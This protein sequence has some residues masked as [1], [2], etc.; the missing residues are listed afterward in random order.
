MTKQT[1]TV[2]LQS[3]VCEVCRKPVTRSEAL[4][5]ETRDHTAYF[6]GQACYE[7]WQ[8]DRSRGTVTREIQEGRGRSKSRDDRLK[9][10]IKQH[11]LRDE[12]RADS[13]EPDEI[14]PA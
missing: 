13:V 10:V 1:S 4:R 3:V 5:A 2:D 11:P 14:P 7:K 8:A 9:R 6:C 12:P